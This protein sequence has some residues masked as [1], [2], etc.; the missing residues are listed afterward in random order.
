MKRA[1]RFHLNGKPTA[2]EIDGSRTAAL[3]AAQRPRPDRRQVRLRRGPVRRLHGA[4]RRRGGALLRDAGRGGRGQARSSPS[5]GSPRASGSTR[6]SRRSSSTAALQCGYCTPGMI[7]NAHALLRRAPAARRG[8]RSSR[9]WRTTSAAAAPTSAILAAV[10]G[11]ARGQGTVRSMTAA[12]RDGPDR[13]A[14]TAAPSSASSA[15]AS[16]CSSPSAR[17]TSSPRGGGAYPE[18]LNAYLRIGEDGRVTVFTGK[19]EMGQGVMTSQ[20]QM[21]AEE[22]GVALDAVD[23]VMGDTD[24]CPW[25]MGTFGSLTTRMFGPVLRAA[26]AE[27]R[28]GAAASS[29]RRSSASRASELMVEDGVVAVAGD[30]GRAGH[31]RRAGPGA[32][33]SPAWSARRRCCARSGSSR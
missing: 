7:L 5:R 17:T 26:A 30:P 16:W 24:R 8:S 11:V 18:D 21:V 15:A 33:G 13:P 19:I 14:S 23:M 4:G 2:L 10:E 1:I 28:S 27:A 32:G 22:L 31:L 6:C 3:G 20:A 29:R 9:G 25:D 12:F